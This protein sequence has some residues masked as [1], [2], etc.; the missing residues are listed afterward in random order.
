M[1]GAEEDRDLKVNQKERIQKL[2]CPRLA[3]ID[4]G[5]MHGHHVHGAQKI[6]RV[7]IGIVYL[8]L[9]TYTYDRV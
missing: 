8:D 7:L 9:L 3:E 1:T 2:E 4:G 6:C 5:N